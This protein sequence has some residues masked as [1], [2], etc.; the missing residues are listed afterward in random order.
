MPRY[1]LLIEFD[2]AA[3]NGTQAQGKGER[4]LHRVL[5]AAVQHLDGEA[6]PVR[7]GSRLDV[8]VSALALPID[9]LLSREWNHDRLLTALDAQLPPDVGVRAVRAVPERWFCRAHLGDKTYTYRLSVRPTKPI[10]ARRCWWLRHLAHPERLQPLTDQLIGSKDLRAFASLR[11]DDTD[12]EDGTRHIS[13]ARWH[14]HTDA[15]GHGEHLLRI[16]GNGFLYHQVRGFVGAM[17]QVAKG[18]TDADGFA[19]LV[20]GDPTA[21]RVGNIAPPEGLTLEAVAGWDTLP[22]P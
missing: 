5:S 17:V 9:V 1:A 6:G 21:R 18:R 14:L 11:H 10:L 2:G 4:T 3:F 20:A 7:I 13:S 19:A 12:A 22:P 8:G 16:S 15:H